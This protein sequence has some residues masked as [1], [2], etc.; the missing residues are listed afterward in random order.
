MMGF[1]IGY[2]LVLIGSLVIIFSFK[3][4]IDSAGKRL[5]IIM[6]KTKEL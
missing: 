3:T 2:L 6:D 4:D 5:K 1:I